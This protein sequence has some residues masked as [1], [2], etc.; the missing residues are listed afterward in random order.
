MAGEVEII[1][2]MTV[3][4]V[5]TT[6][7]KNYQTYLKNYNAPPIHKSIALLSSYNYFGDE[8]ILMSNLNHTYSAVCV[9]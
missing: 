2:E 8:D 5:S 3:A 4:N 7:T 9:S 6:K 1:R